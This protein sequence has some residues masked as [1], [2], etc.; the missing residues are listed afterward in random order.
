MCVIVGTLLAVMVLIVKI[1][2]YL[3]PFS[4]EEVKSFT[5]FLAIVWISSW[6]LIN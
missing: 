2:F 3:S 6:E 5:E 4:F 1:P